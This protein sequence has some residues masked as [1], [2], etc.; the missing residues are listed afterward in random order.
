M[1]RFHKLFLNI[2]ILQPVRVNHFHSVK[3]FKKSAYIF[4]A[5]ERIICFLF[6]CISYNLI[7]YFFIFK[8]FY[9]IGNQIV[10]FIIHMLLYA[11]SIFNKYKTD[12]IRCIFFILNN[13]ICTFPCITKLHIQKT[14]YIIIAC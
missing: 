2:T 8:R 4:K 7:K 11:Y 6:L 3:L 10:P 9:N 14:I 5:S 1:T 12:F 13:I